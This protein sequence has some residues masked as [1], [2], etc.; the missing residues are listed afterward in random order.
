MMHRFLVTVLALL[1]AEARA[2]VPEYR[3]DP[4]QSLVSFTATVN[5]APSTGTFGQLTGIVHF[6]PAALA[7]SHA[8]VTIP[9]GSLH[10]DYEEVANSLQKEAWFNTAHH[11]LATL[12]IDQFRQT[13]DNSYEA[14]ALL[15]LRGVARAVPLTFHLDA[16]SEQSAKATGT[17]TLNRRDFEVGTG[18]WADTT[19]V[20]DPVQIEFTVSATH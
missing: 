16:L 9:L 10:S 12:K 18:E 1:A 7:E 2:E 8:E 17:A 11:P 6:D 4:E 3:I 5:G 19:V 15:T 13:D 14:Q 20:A